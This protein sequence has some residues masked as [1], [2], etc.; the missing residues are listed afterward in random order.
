[1]RDSKMSRPV[2]R[3]KGAPDRRAWGLG[4]ALASGLLLSFWGA[5]ALAH[6]SFAAYDQKVMKTVSGT[7]KEFDWN[8]PH[9]GVTVTY[10]D[11]QGQVQ[12]VSV[13]TGAPS[14]IASQGFRPKDFR[15]GTKVTLSWHPNRNGLPG[16]ELAEIKLEDGRVLHGGFGGGPPPGGAPPGAAPGTPPGTPPGPPPGAAPKP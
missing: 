15:V 8:A 14:T 5:T 6:H 12:E 16:G 11:A 10:V 7:L 2:P 3:R 13:T 4:P 9:S 1:V